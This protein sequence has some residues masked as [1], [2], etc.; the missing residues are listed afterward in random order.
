VE[1]KP[2]FGNPT[3]FYGISYFHLEIPAGNYGNYISM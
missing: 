3:E 2:E 1:P